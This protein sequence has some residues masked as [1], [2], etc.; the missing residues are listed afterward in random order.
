[1][2]SAQ[3]FLRIVYLTSV[4]SS[5]NR[6]KKQQSQM[7]I[8]PKFTELV[9][10]GFYT[11]G[12]SSKYK[13]ELNVLINVLKYTKNLACTRFKNDKRKI[14][15]CGETPAFR[16]LSLLVKQRFPQNSNSGYAGQ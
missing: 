4:D 2:H 5:N 14:L 12:K 15:I 9:S 8:V 1:M 11:P 13:P 3:T 10:W 7:N 16:T 6:I